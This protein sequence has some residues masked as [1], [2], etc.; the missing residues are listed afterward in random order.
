MT[1]NPVWP[2]GTVSVKA[3]E[4]TGVQNIAYI[5]ST[6]GGTAVGT[7]TVTTRDH[8]WNVDD[9]LNGRH[10][11]I[12]SRGFVDSMGDAD[13]PVLG[14]LIDSVLYAK[15]VSTSVARV[16]WFSRNSSGIYQVSPSQDTGTVT[17]LTSSYQTV[18]AVPTDVYGEIWMYT[19]NIGANN[20]DRYR[21]CK[22]IFRSD[23]TTVNSWTIPLAVQAISADDPKSGVKFGN[24]TESS[25]LD[26]RVR[27]DDATSG[28]N[29]NYIVTYRAL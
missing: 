11:F 6:M 8:F 9:D 7:N 13:D 29:W 14:T 10:R 21:T 16:E 28:L 17:N 5:K 22:G 24:G 25:G 26:I 19:T 27:L 1:W 3:N 23:G 2:D 15:T 18:L 20:K 12:Q 4:A